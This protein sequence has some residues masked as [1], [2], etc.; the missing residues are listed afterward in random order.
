MV[1]F[2]DIAL[3]D[4]DIVELVGAVEVFDIAVDKFVVVGKIDDVEIDI[5]VI[6]VVD[7]VEFDIFV[8]FH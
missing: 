5:V 2:V 8:L 4:V 3:V 6:V 7:S 1:D